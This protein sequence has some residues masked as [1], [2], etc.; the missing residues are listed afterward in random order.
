[1]AIS[2]TRSLIPLLAAVLSAGCTS[3]PA[4]EA[5]GL[6]NQTQVAGAGLV[7]DK[8]GALI[9]DKGATLISDKG[10]HLVFNNSG[11][12][13]GVIQG[14]SAEVLAKA[15]LVANAG[16]SIVSPSGSTLI[17]NHAAGFRIHSLSGLLAPGAGAQVT[18][19]DADGNALTDAA[20]TADA[21]GRYTIE[22][23][24]PSG[25]VVF[26]KAT[27]SAGGKAVTLMATARAPHEVGDVQASVDP[28]TTLVSRKVTTLLHNAALQ[29]EQVG[30]DALQHVAARLADTLGTDDVA[31]AALGS[32]KDGE[33]VFDRVLAADPALRQEVGAMADSAGTAL[34]QPTT[35][36]APP[37][38]N[39]LA[40]GGRPG[41]ADGVGA[42]A[43]FQYPYSVAADAA[44]NVYVADYR[45]HCIRKVAPDGTVSTLAGNGTAGFA[46]GQ[47]AAARFTSPR[48]IAS[49][50]AGNLFVVDT[51]NAR[52]RKVT[53]DGT[54]TTV[55]GDG[56]AGYFDGPADKAEFND[57]RGIT[58][59]ASG[60]LYVA[61]TG[62]YRVRKIAADGTV[63]TLATLPNPSEGATHPSEAKLTGP[64]G[65]AADGHGRLFV[66][67]TTTNTIQ[68]IDANGKLS[69]LA[70]SG[71]W[72]DS[73]G[74]PAAASF[75]SPVALTMAADGTLYVADCFSHR[76]RQVST[77]GTVST[78]AGDGTVGSTDTD[79]LHSRFYGPY[80]LT[81]VGTDRLVVADTSNQALRTVKLP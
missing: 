45:N 81:L 2:K 24:K 30:V 23:L 73:D 38:V 35:P 32:D 68:L 56:T 53:P 65:L 25:P 60:N 72:G 13:T 7:S 47:G 78:L 18:V 55:A 20:V 11:R 16:A 50:G 22:K 52:I 6:Q 67:D 48:G 39:L 44:G 75:R 4:P 26:V 61:D 3:T 79:R 17:G 29:P 8:G 64:Y 12:L 28:A 51:G 69:T 15:S 54:V 42:K 41:Y 58:T 66:A 59:D 27:Y 33:A 77:D 31:T 34:T 43:A 76:I 63:S 5:V 36:V 71:L 14:P 62:N 74:S 1:M 21:S 46:D 37:Q 40:G 10:G 49:D 80:G 9:S 57:A 19:V 70:G